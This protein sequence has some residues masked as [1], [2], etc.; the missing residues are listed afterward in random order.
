V[1]SSKPKKAKGK[2]E[3]KKHAARPTPS[4]KK[5][6]SKTEAKP[7]A[8]QARPPAAPPPGKH[9][10][11][12]PPAKGGSGARPGHETA[13]AKGPAKGPPAKPGPGKPAPGGKK[14]SRK[15]ATLRRGPDGE[16]LGVGELLIPGG[17]LAPEEVQY[18][19][20]GCVAAEHAAGP[21][22]VEEI[23]TKR[24]LR[25]AI[26]DPAAERADLNRVM[27]TMA[28]RFDGSIEPSLPARPQAQRRTFQSVV[29]RARCRR[30]EIGSFLRGLDLGRTETSHM[31]SHGE[32]SLDS[33]MKWAAHLEN[34]GEAEDPAQGDFTQ[35]HRFLDN[36]ENTTEALIV[37]I[38]ATLRRLRDRVRG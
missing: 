34:L 16:I 19:F 3:A 10:A 20:R 17:P 22:G 11:P 38:E 37:D 13:P 35:H 24:A 31:D 15:S 2:A 8:A 1:P 36:L 18:F 32:A 6:A 21:A 26:A 25:G 4:P 7:A 27:Q 23:L 33:L 5:P 9:G 28:L 14:S 12:A 29:E 30:R